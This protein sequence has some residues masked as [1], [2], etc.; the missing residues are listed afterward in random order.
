M[1]KKVFAKS[2]AQRLQPPTMV[3]SPFPSVSFAGCAWL[4]PYHLGVIEALRQEPAFDSALYLGASSGSLAAIIAALGMDTRAILEH[5]LQF[6]ADA[7]ERRLGPLGRMTRYV[8]LGLR[9]HLPDQAWLKAAGRAKISV[10]LLPHLKHELI[11][12]GSC[13]DQ[14]DVI[15]LLLGSC[16]IP[17]YYEKPVIWGWRVM[18]DGGLRNNQPIW[19]ASTIRVS[20]QGSRTPDQVDIKPKNSSSMREVLFPE[21]GRL[22]SLYEEGRADGE[23]WL[24]S[25]F[26]PIQ[27]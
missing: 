27:T 24:Q 20:P 22:I 11:D 15:R 21:P 3:S 26:R 1:L 10:T 18:I 9:E 2:L 25:S 8:G 16:Y 14:A 12:V 13:Q 6:A 19:D 7:Q 5:T 17:I 23:R 4:F